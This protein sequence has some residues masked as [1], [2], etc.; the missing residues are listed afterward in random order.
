MAL[1]PTPEIVLV[2]DP[3]NSTGYCLVSIGLNPEG[4]AETGVIYSYGFLDVD[5][6]SDFSGDWCLDLQSQL[7]EIC[8]RHSAQHIAMEDFFFSKRFA[9]GSKVNVELR[10][11]IAMLARELG[12]NYT[13]LGISEWK[14]FISGRSTPTKEQKKKWGPARAKKLAIQEALWTRYQIRFP[15][16]S[17]S[18]KTNKPIA[19]RLD[20][21]DVVAQTIYFCKIYLDVKFIETIV[22][23]PKDVSIKGKEGFI[24]P[25]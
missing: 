24:Y 3:A 16:H 12:L 22:K 17:R 20:I 5:T 23:I 2:L 8:K 21:V 1:S 19:F 18:K 13:I 14:K 6:S 9:N 25:S 15:N 11:A 7:R 4:K 10:T